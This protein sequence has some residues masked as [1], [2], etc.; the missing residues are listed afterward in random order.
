MTPHK[1][2]K[3]TLKKLENYHQRL[4][5]YWNK[6]LAGEEDLEYSDFAG[7]K[8]LNFS[9]FEYWFRDENL[10]RDTAKEIKYN[11]EFVGIG[12]RGDGTQI[13]LWIQQGEVINA[14]IALIG[15]EGELGFIAPN[16]LTLMMLLAQGF[17]VF[18]LLDFST[19]LWHSRR[20]KFI[21]Y[22]RDEF[23]ISPISD[24]KTLLDK[25]KEQTIDLSDYLK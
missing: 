13:A 2:E 18:Q 16:Y 21:N 11:K 6:E 24:V 12:Q 23:G 15:S 7:C 3:E 25:L 4:G 17:D 8:E 9:V 22:L 5:A 20:E 14:P 19:R 1:M 10:V